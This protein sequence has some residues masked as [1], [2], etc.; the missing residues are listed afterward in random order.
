MTTDSMVIEAEADHVLAI[1]VDPSKAMRTTGQRP[2][3]I[4]TCDRREETQA[5]RIVGQPL[6]G[7]SGFKGFDQPIKPEEIGLL[8]ARKD[9]AN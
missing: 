6:K 3:L 5:V 9:A 7:T 4:C 1:A 2:V 8:Y